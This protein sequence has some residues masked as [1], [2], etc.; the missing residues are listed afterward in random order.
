MEIDK[1]ELYRMITRT[2]ARSQYDDVHDVIQ[3]TVVH[4]W[5]RQ[6]LCEAPDNQQAYA[7]VIAKRM[8]LKLVQHRERFLYPDRDTA[9][10]WETLQE[11]QGCLLS[12]QNID[13]DLDVQCVLRVL[14]DHYALILRR[15]Y[16]D[17]APL[18]VIA[19][20]LQVSPPAM[21]KRH[22]RALSLARD[23]FRKGATPAEDP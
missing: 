23:Y 2:F 22:Q 10:G 6:H 5:E 18:R 13:Q 19:D 17:G 7:T 1:S 3:A 15:H 20:E 21:R 8:M 16:L 9:L 4:S 11:E 12:E 14:P